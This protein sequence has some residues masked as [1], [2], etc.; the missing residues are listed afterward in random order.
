M[1]HTITLKPNQRMYIEPHDESPDNT[2]AN[3]RTYELLA[4]LCKFV[5]NEMLTKRIGRR[6]R[7]KERNFFEVTFVGG[8]QLARAWKLQQTKSLPITLWVRFGRGPM[9]RYTPDKPDLS[10]LLRS[11][12]V[13]KGT[14]PKK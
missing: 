2:F 14:T 10:K 11:G 4:D 8:E 1:E 5:D 12:L 3:T 9:M 7:S 6:D 13:T